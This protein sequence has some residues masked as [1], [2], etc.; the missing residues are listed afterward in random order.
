M[1]LLRVFTNKGYRDFHHHDDYFHDYLLSFLFIFLVEF[2][3]SAFLFILSLSN[4]VFSL[5]C[6]WI[7]YGFNALCNFCILYMV[8]ALKIINRSFSENYPMRKILYT[9][10]FIEGEKRDI[11]IKM[12]EHIE[13]K[14]SYKGN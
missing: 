9:L 8:P 12:R 13:Q 7:I 1:T 5:N 6:G 2:L 14:S 3:P 11:C 10:I 4:F